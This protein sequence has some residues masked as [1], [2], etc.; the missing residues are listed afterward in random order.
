MIPITDELTFRRALPADAPTIRD[1]HSRSVRT[2]CRSHYTDEEIYAWTS[3][4]EVRSYEEAILGGYEI[5]HIL[6]THQQGMAF[7]SLSAGSLNTGSSSQAELGALYVHPDFTGR[8]YGVELLY[9]TENQALR[10]GIETL[11]LDASLNAVLFY[12]ARGYE[13]LQPSAVVLSG[14][15]ELPAIRMKRVL[16]SR[17]H[18]SPM[19]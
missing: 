14:G 13:I 18:P 4:S 5:L 12:Q 8:G 6:E 15:M 16:D 11:Y 17:S 7:S 3:G 2:L 9:F 10:L 1:I 19:V